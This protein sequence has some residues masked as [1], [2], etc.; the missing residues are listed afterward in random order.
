MALT[1]RQW[2]R[3]KEITQEQMA[4]VLGI[5]VNTYQNWEDAPEKISI[6]K[7]LEIAKFFKVGLEDIS[8]KKGAEEI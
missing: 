5:H 2:R 6:E 3:A 1:L 8:F 4:D 7:A